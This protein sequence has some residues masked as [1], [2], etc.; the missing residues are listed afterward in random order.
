M[1]TQQNTTAIQS[2]VIKHWWRRTVHDNRLF[3]RLVSED[4]QQLDQL[5]YLLAIAEKVNE[6]R[7]DIITDDYP[8]TVEAIRLHLLSAQRYF[9]ECLQALLIK[10]PI[11]A[12]MLHNLAHAEISMLQYIFMTHGIKSYIK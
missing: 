7:V 8:Y 3:I 5:P 4:I 11:E 6:G 2:T 1:I 9:I 10:D 12:Q